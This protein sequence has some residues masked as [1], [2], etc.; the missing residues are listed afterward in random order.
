MLAKRRWQ[1]HVRS[2][3]LYCIKFVVVPAERSE[4][5]DPVPSTQYP[6][7]STQY[8]VPSTVCPRE[9]TEYWVSA[10]RVPTKIAQV[11]QRSRTLLRPRFSWVP[12]A[13]TTGQRPSALHAIHRVAGRDDR[14]GWAEPVVHQA[15][16][17][18]VG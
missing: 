16:L 10:I 14:L 17:H 9:E 6:V 2:E 18:A 4:S 7:P 8:P 5:R 12:G 15:L 3:T 11:Q 13:G 1:R